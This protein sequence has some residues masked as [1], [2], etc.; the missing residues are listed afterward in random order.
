MCIVEVQL[1]LQSNN[2]RHK[3][4][5]ECK[6]L[7]TPTGWRQPVGYLQMRQRSEFGT[8]NPAS[9]QSRAQTL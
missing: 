7:K 6:R 4:Q 9:G 3:T 5:T 8:T 2:K 1:A